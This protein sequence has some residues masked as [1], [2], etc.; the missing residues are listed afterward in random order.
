MATLDEE[1]DLYESLKDLPDFECF[2][3]PSS[4]F[5]KFNIEPRGIIG[6]K[7]YIESN[8]AIKMALQPKQLPPLIIDKP[9]QNGKLVEM[10][11]SEVVPVEVVSRPF[12]L[13]EGELF[14]AVLPFLTKDY[15]SALP[16]SPQ[17]EEEHSQS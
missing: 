2:P 17:T 12:E 1:R 8:Y 14:P 5:K 13:K 11:E 15:E 3:I 9:Q 4:W 10:Q 7:E 16:T 6:P